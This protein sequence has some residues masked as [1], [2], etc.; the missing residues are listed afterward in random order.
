M[1]LKTY[2]NRCYLFAANLYTETKKCL[3]N[4]KDVGDAPVMLIPKQSNCSVIK[5]FCNVAFFFNGD[6][7]QMHFH[8]V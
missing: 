5:C 2:L 1:L 3:Q 6:F 4:L 7:E 8:Y